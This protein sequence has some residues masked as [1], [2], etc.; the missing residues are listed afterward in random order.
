[1][2]YS[3]ERLVHFQCDECHKWWSV[4]DPEEGKEE[5]WC[6][7]CGYR[8]VTLMR[9]PPVESPQN[10]MVTHIFDNTMKLDRETFNRMME[11]G[12]EAF[13]RLA[14]ID[15]KEETGTEESLTSD[16]LNCD[17]LLFLDKEGGKW[18]HV[19]GVNNHKPNPSSV[20]DLC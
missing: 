3:I 8:S 6:P 7:W 2:K 16:C 10:E 13:S 19:S 18:Q 5:W 14:Q 11:E 20:S 12:Q 15:K 9:V 4:G 1:M 17:E